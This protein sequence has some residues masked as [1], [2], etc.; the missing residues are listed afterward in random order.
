MEADPNGIKKFQVVC[1]KGLSIAAIA[2]CQLGI[3]K[4]MSLMRIGG[5]IET[6]TLR[7]GG[8]H[9]KYYGDRQTVQAELDRR[10]Q[11]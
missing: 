5:E 3:E 11:P 1:L 10:T 7:S 9:A 2:S 4:G 6:I 8:S